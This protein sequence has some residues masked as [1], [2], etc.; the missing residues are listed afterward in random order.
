[1]VATGVIRVLEGCARTA[2]AGE[3]GEGTHAGYIGSTELTDTSDAPEKPDEVFVLNL[4]PGNATQRQDTPF[5]LSIL[6]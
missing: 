1:M 4:E 5:R 3:P 2:T 6:C